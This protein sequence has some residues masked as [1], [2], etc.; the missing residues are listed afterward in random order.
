MRLVLASMIVLAACKSASDSP[1]AGP[2][3][4]CAAM[5]I[6]AGGAASVHVAVG[7]PNM[8]DQPAAGWPVFDQEPSCVVS[9]TTA[10]GGTIVMPAPAP[11]T[12][13]AWG[14]TTHIPSAPQLVS[15]YDVAPGT[16][17]CI[18][19]SVGGDSFPKG[20]STTIN[21]ASSSDHTALTWDGGGAANCSV[22]VAISWNTIDTG[23]AT[24]QLIAPNTT[25]GQALP[26]LDPPVVPDG[27]GLTVTAQRICP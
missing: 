20:T 4:A 21:A 19:C 12:I 25:T 7:D 13:T 24:W 15:Y 22:V 18:A 10:S 14:H 17:L 16:D 8:N 23:T 5:S 1:D 6:D 3:A 9:G 27:G 11:V 26:Q 2:L